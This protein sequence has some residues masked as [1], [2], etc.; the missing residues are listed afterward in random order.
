MHAITLLTFKGCQSTIDFRDA[1]EARPFASELG[2]TL[3]GEAS[4]L[5]LLP[6]VQGTDGY[7]AASFVVRR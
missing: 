5:R 1:L 2:R 6:H 4:V 7:F 3:A